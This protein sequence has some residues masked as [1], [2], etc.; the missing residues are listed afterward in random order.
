MELNTMKGKKQNQRKGERGAVLALSAVAMLSI[1][2]AT[3]LAIDI[4]HFYVA[5]NELQN[6]ADAS[7]LAGVSALNASST[8]IV[9]ATNR[10]VQVM[11]SYDFNKKGVSFPRENVLFAVN[12]DGPYMSEATA[13]ASPGDIRFVQVT[14]PASP[15]GVSFAGSVLGNSKN[16][17]A[18]ATAG[19][20]ISLNV[21]CN[22]F[23]AYVLDI[24]ENPISPLHDYVFRSEPGGFV[25]P[26]NYQ[27][28]APAD[29]GG[30]DTRTGMANGV[31]V[32]TQP[33]DIV[34][35]KPGVT[36]GD[37]RQGVNTRFDIYHGTVDPVISPPD[38]NVAEGIT[39]VEYRDKLV[40]QAPRH[41]G[42]DQRR[43][44]F[45]PIVKA[46]PDGGRAEVQVDRFGLF[47]LKQSVGGGDGGEIVA[48]YIGDKVMAG[49]GSFDPKGG[50]PNPLL[51]VPVLYK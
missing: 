13:M 49:R 10:A 20:S 23:P 25:S 31:D 29:P 33:G 28:L 7:A 14:T 21:I 26:G 43:V 24:P 42:T 6:A 48:Y 11:N 22:W 32:C 4:S 1:L 8:G 3:G 12:L 9:A 18:T 27:L 15:V 30:A 47:F 5:K 34:P 45:M 2:L 19:Y 44:I 35:T 39:W 40:V 50:P 17:S 16:L 41:P 51:A 38:T 46:L 36:A 37:V